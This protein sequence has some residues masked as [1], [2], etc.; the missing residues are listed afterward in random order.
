MGS[1]NSIV[2]FY[3]GGPTV[4]NLMKSNHT[5]FCTQS[6]KYLHTIRHFVTGKAKHPNFTQGQNSINIKSNSHKSTMYQ[7]AMV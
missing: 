2:L 3:R 7:G 6:N 1:Y 5:V 4:L